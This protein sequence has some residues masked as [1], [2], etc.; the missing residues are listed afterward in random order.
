VRVKV[1][2]GRRKTVQVMAER[3]D[4]TIDVNDCAAI[5]ETVSALLDVEDPIVGEYILEV[6]SPGIDRPLTKREDFE[7]FAGKTAKIK[8][9][10]PLQGRK[11]FGGRLK[12]VKGQ[13]V[14]LEVEDAAGG[15]QV[16]SL[17]LGDIAE[18]QLVLTD[19]LIRESLKG[20]PGRSAARKGTTGE[21][22]WRKPR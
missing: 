19:E 10:E 12:G 15:P 8:L 14:E 5:S 20:S 17:P 6:S 21:P 3:A 1:S 9:D 18:A 11:R 4:G 7:R 2:G 13:S 22:R 16:V